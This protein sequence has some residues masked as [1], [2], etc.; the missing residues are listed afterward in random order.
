MTYA[1]PL[2][3]LGP[4]SA[5][6]THT[7]FRANSVYDPDYSWGGDQCYGHVS[8][9]D[10]FE[11]YYVKKSK[12]TLLGG[13]YE[14]DTSVARGVC[15][16]LGRYHRHFWR[17]QSNLNTIHGMCT[18][19]G[20]KIFKIPNQGIDQDGHWIRQVVPSKIIILTAMPIRII[21][22]FACPTL[23]THFFGMLWLRVFQ[24]HQPMWRMWTS[25]F[26]WIMILCIMIQLISFR[27]RIVM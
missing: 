9:T 7:V 14:V 3:D 13:D 1:Y 11:R 18:A 17:W 20:G 26:R 24:R 5:L 22:L 15:L 8:M 4:T 2:T 19:N 6:A 12:F 21:T 25:R 10:R 23:R 16:H 27:E